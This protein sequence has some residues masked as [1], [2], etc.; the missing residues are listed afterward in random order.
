MSL[1]AWI[2]VLV[3]LVPALMLLSIAVAVRICLL[4]MGD[5]Q[6]G[7][8]SPARSPTPRASDRKRLAR[9]LSPLRSG[10]GRPSRRAGTAH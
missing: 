3:V 2:G 6:S 7:S 10:P 9:R 8:T 5:Q 1:N 4:V